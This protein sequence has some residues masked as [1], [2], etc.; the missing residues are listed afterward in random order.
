MHCLMNGNTSAVACDV[1]INIGLIKSLIKKVLYETDS[2][3][4]RQLLQSTTPCCHCGK[5]PRGH[6]ALP[7]KINEDP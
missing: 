6:S 3:T 1:E 7:L 4:F 2:C 5:V